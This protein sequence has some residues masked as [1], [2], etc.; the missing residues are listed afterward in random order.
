MGGLGW[1]QGVGSF[2]CLE[3]VA[4]GLFNLFLMNVFWRTCC[5]MY[6]REISI[7]CSFFFPTLYLWGWGSKKVVNRWGSGQG[8]FSLVRT[9]YQGFKVPLMPLEGEGT[10]SLEKKAGTFP[11]PDPHRKKQHG[12]RMLGG[13]AVDVYWGPVPHVRSWGPCPLHLSP[14]LHSSLSNSEDRPCSRGRDME[15]RSGSPGPPPWAPGGGLRGLKSQFSA[16]VGDSHSLT[17]AL[18]ILPPWSL[19]LVFCAVPTPSP[20]PCFQLTLPWLPYSI[21]L[22]RV[23]CGVTCG[24]HIPGLCSPCTFPPPYPN[25]LIFISSSST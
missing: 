6:K 3:A 4:R 1:G 8:V 13:A 24:P 7:L 20:G 18:V 21:P 16:R 2:L 19:P 5:N 22:T 23:Q 12:P 10:G 9:R 25:P 11:P 14:Q 15:C 17:R